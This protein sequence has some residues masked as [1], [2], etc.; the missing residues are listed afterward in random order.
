MKNEEYIRQ[1]ELDEL[2]GLYWP[3]EFDIAP[4]YLYDISRPVK[5]E[6]VA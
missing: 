5:I 1:F 2:G 3:N 6:A 4:D